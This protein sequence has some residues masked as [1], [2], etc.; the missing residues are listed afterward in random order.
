MFSSPLHA[1]VLPPLDYGGIWKQRASKLSY[2]TEKEVTRRIYILFLTIP[3][4]MLVIKM[5]KE[6]KP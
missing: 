2:D 6:V 4:M 1:P 5:M 3:L